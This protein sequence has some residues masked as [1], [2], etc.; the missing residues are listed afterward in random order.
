MTRLCNT[1]CRSLVAAVLP[2]PI[3]PSLGPPPFYQLI[4]SVN[5]CHFNIECENTDF[6]TFKGIV[7]QDF[8][9]C[10]WYRWIPSLHIATP[11]GACW[12]FKQVSMSSQIFDYLCRGGASSP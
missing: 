6:I 3:P 5:Y 2:I 7:S 1:A 8:E 4:S 11:S 10:F 9:L 12:I